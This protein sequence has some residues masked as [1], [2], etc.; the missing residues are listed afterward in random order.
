MQTQSAAARETWRC[1][2]AKAVEMRNAAAHETWPRRSD[3]AKAMQTQSAA[4]RETWRCGSAKAV[5]M[6]NAAAYK[7]WPRWSDAACEA[8][9]CGRAG[10][11]RMGGRAM[12]PNADSV[13]TMEP[14]PVAAAPT[15]PATGAAP[16][17]A[18]VPFVTAR[19]PAGALPA[20]VVPAIIAVIEGIV[21]NCL[22]R[23]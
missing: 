14:Y 17:Q 9:G 6:R 11:E 12:M 3:A 21:L 13:G 20:S 10:G 22:D 18:V 15:V 5:E 16:S 2:S 19:V 1:G 23:R 4:A 8:R 7:T